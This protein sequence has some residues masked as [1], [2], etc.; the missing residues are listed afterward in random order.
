[1]KKNMAAMTV[2]PEKGA[3]QVFIPRE[4][5][6]TAMLLIPFFAAAILLR[7]VYWPEFVALVAIGCSFAMKDSLVVIA[8]QRFVWKQTHVE[9]KVA[10]RSALLQS[11]LLVACGITLLIVRDWPPLVLLFLGSVA[12]T[13]LAVTL[14]VRN[15]QRSEWFQVAS[16]VAL[17]ST[18]LVTC[19]S[20]TS[21][22]PE[23]CWLL[24]FLCVLQAVAGIFVIHAR[25]DARVAARNRQV[26]NNRNRW[27]ALVCE[28]VLLLTGLI[29]AFMARPWIAAALFIAAACYLSELRRQKNPQ[30]LQTPLKRIG[31]EALLLSTGYALVIIIGLW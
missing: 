26:A 5:G 4:H 6:A 22:I 9:T 20:A 21:V 29:F 23:W 3:A 17:S 10:M 1:M 27:A 12:F 18:C 7:R 15:R 28:F 31:I 30:S 2:T 25:L 13:V 24:W 19:L 8:R 14:N 16:A 11:L